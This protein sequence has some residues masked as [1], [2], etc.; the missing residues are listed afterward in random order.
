[1]QTE[2]LVLSILVVIS[3]FKISFLLH[4]YVFNH[5]FMST[6]INLCENLITLYIYRCLFSGIGCGLRGG[7][8]RVE[9]LPMKFESFYLMVCFC[10]VS[11][12][13]GGGVECVSESVI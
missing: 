9:L 6:Y 2:I 7:G 10:L 11:F 3:I 8:G 1:M 12:F 5:V 13:L 4:I